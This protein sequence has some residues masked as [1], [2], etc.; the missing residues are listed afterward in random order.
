MSRHPISDAHEWIDEILTVPI[1][2]LA[3]PQPRE[4]AWQNRR[5]K[6]GL[7]NFTLV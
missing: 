3:K 7:F 5:G 1:Y 6:K 2:Y 4:R